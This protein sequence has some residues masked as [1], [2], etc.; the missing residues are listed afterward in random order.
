MVVNTSL[1][2]RGE[3]IVCTPEDALACFLQTDIDV[4]AVNDLIVTGKPAGTRGPA[5]SPRNRRI[6]ADPPPVEAERIELFFRLFLTPLSSRYGR[7]FARRL[8]GETTTG[9]AYSPPEAAAEFCELETLDAVGDLLR[10]M[11]TADGVVSAC[12]LIQPLLELTEEVIDACSD[13][14]LGNLTPHTYT[15]F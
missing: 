9:S 11:W 13:G 7:D 15:L 14:D 3:P 10:Q 4:L 5:E 8:G 12:E 6:N 1:N 2:V